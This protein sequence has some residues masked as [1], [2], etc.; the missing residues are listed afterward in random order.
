MPQ[1]RLPMRKTREVLRL[2]AMGLS[3]NQV[4]RASGVA[5]TTVRR[6]LARAEAAGVSWPLPDELDDAE[7]DRLLFG[8]P[9]PTRDQASVVPDWAQVQRELRGKHVTLQ[10]VHAEYVEQV[11]EARAY[12]YS[13]FCELYRGWEGRVEPVM[14]Q[15]HTAGEKLFVDWAGMTVPVVDP[16]TGEVFDAQIWVGTLGASSYTY[17][18]AMRSQQQRDW[19][20][21]HVACFEHLGAVPEIVVPDNTKT[22]VTSPCRYDPDVNVAYAEL[23][24]H[25]QLAVVPTRVA[26]PRDK[27]KV[28]SGVLVVERSVLAPLRKRTFFGL[29]EL[30]AAIEPLVE[31]VNERTMQHVGKSRRQ[32][33][34]QVDRPAMRTLPGGRYEY[35]EWTKARVAPDYHV[36][37]DGHYY[38][39]PFRLI[40]RQLDVRMTA[41]TIEIFDQRR[42]VASHPRSFTHGHT[43][44]PAHM[45][46]S[47]RRHAEWTP[48]RIRRWARAEAGPQAAELVDRIM[49]EM[50]HPEQGFRSALG[51]MR[52]GK[53]YGPE[54]L[55][56]ACQRALMSGAVRYRSVKA[57]LERGLDRQPLPDALPEVP[58]AR[59]HNIRGPGYFAC[60]GQ[61]P[62]TTTEG[63]DTC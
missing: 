60:P 35:A 19:L 31:R 38:S 40:G 56:A 4:S 45:P 15:R 41:R 28:E 8:E 36:A 6:Y 26:K 51:V 46:D 57:I 47:H 1:A 5:R 13:R 10:L 34:D 32:L 23:A 62:L 61:L 59:H 25:Y 9:D 21:A 33:F 29:G 20:A 37:V 54:R 63:D 2:K 44:I 24:E 17:A 22:A 11:G 30:N 3:D 43:T 14:R 58:P 18:R 50:P 27:G 49:R 16:A 53:R 12:S 7:L 52:L 39:V 48:E 42:R 55:E